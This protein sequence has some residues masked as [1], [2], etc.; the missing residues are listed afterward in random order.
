M[1]IDPSLRP[2]FSPQVVAILGA[3]LD[4]TKLGYGLSRNLVQ[5]GYQG[6]I[7]FINLKGGHLM[8]FPVYSHIREV[9]DPVDLAVLL[10]PAPAVPQ[11]I[12][13]CALRGIKAQIIASGGFRETGAEGAKLEDKCLKIVR[14]HGVRL[15]G[16]NCIG[17]IDTHLPID[18]TFLSP[19]GPTPGDVAFISHSGAICAA[20]IDWARGQGFG[21]SRM[22]S[23]GNQSDVTETDLLA[24]VAEDHFTRVITLYLEGVSDG[25]KFL[26]QAQ[27][28][29][30]LKP[31]VALKV[32]RYERGQQ[33]VASHTGAL[34]GLESAYNAAF[35]RAGVIRAESTEQLFDWA[36]A[37]AWCPLP[38]GRSVGVLTN[39]GG[40]GV[41]AVDALEA[42]GLEIADL[43]IETEA[44]LQ[45]HLDPAASLKNP[46]DM[47]AAASPQQY[48]SCLQ[49]LLSDPQVDSVMVILPPPPMHSAGG[50]A[51]AIIPVIYSAEKPVVVALMGERLIQEA[52]EHFR[53]ARVPEYRFPERAAEALAVLNQRADYL[54]TSNEHQGESSPHFEDINPDGASSI[55]SKYNPGEIISQADA[56][57]LMDAYGIPS[58][59]PR[60]ASTPDQAAELAE[61]IGYPVAL[62]IASP[63][64]T[65][66]SD[67]GGVLLNLHNS[68]EVEIGF[69]QIVENGHAG[70]PDAEILGVHI[71]RMIPSGQDVI[72]GAIQDPQFGPL[73]MFGSGGIEVEGLKDVQFALAPLS[74]AE[75]N[76]ILADT[77]A[78][79]KLRGFRSLNP[80]DQDAVVSAILRLAQL[81]S[82][83]PQL[84]EIEINP[85]TVLEEGNGAFAVDVRAKIGN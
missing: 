46:V 56:F 3:S 34:A 64:I 11:A 85:L 62:K 38:K 74:S 7:H 68:R 4:P 79:K 83:F 69:T 12:E 80:A 65:H 57:G 29:T 44:A 17:L 73:V 28:V 26:E 10:I 35:R 14:E 9:P 19:P 84:T 54:A 67:V 41:T 15:L 22:V 48:A 60:L 78:G 43:R 21:L 51:K 70:R 75:A 2:F 18:T 24:P 63:Q 77:W 16:P 71:Q 33:A 55:L 45:D 8:G 40:P 49:I 30:R 6:A 25:R 76:Q 13:D 66:K 53:A 42:Q 23:L 47:L 50:I 5:S 81:T 72:I 82:D 61:E 59:Q 20:V 52:V 31:V 37:L 32:G 58:M 27:R 36:R 39:A 1:N